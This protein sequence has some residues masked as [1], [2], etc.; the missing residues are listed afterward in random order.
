MD[1]ITVLLKSTDGVNWSEVSEVY[2][3]FGNGEPAM[4]FMP[5]KSIIAV[6]RCGSLGTGGYEFGNATGNTIIAISKPPYREW[7]YAHSF[8][9][10]LDGATLF[11]VRGR[12]FAAGRNHLGPRFDMGNHLAKKR[13]AIY[14][15]KRDRLVHLF[16]LPSNGDTSYTG[17]VTRGDTVY[18]SYYTCPITKDYP[19][20]AGIC[21]LPKTDVRIAQFSAAGMLKLADQAQAVK[22]GIK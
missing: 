9:T 5:D 10:R 18:V 19:W 14:E 2:T 12:I 20:I 8:I 17:V 1:T 3:A 7:S 4:E 22:K 15:V 13:T 21:F 6:L 16:D 11:P